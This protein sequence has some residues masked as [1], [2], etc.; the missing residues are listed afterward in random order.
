MQEIGVDIMLND[1]EEMF[2]TRVYIGWLLFLSIAADDVTKVRSFIDFVSFLIF[3][4]MNEVL[5]STSLMLK[6][7][8]HAFESTD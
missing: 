6:E 3:I 1:E 7:V 8:G 5:I 4:E 2:L